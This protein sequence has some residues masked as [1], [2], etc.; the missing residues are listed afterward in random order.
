[1]SSP[2]NVSYYMELAYPVVLRKDQDG[3]FIARIEEL[4]GCLSHGETETEALAHLREAQQLWIEDCL[5]SGQPVPEPEPEEELP[6]GKWVQRAP[7]TLHKRLT[8]VAKH[9]K[10][11]LNQLVTSMLSEAVAIRYFREIPQN[12]QV[13]FGIAGDPWENAFVADVGGSWSVERP[14][15]ELMAVL[16]YIANLTPKPKRQTFQLTDAYTK[17]ITEYATR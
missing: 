15:G 9:E 1:M 6:S 16:G 14:K 13:V 3:D 17:E 5:E 2:N 8:D 12:P 11:S 4:P 7:R 10:V